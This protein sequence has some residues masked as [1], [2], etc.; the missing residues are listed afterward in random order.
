MKQTT[1]RD[2]TKIIIKISHKIKNYLPRSKENKV[3]HTLQWLNI[4]FPR[5]WKNKRVST[6]HWPP[7]NWTPTDHL[8]DPPTDPL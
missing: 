3:N 4:I 7:V 6:K 5:F 2:A 8:T 1:L